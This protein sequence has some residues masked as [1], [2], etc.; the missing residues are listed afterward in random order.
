[1]SNFLSLIFPQY[2]W[3]HSVHKRKRLPP[4]KRSLVCYLKGREVRLSN[5]SSY[6]R[7]LH[8]YAAQQLPGLLKEREFHLGTL[9][10]V[11]ASQWLNHRQVV[12]GTKCNTVSARSHGYCLGVSSTS[13]WMARNVTLTISPP[14]YTRQKG[15]RKNSNMAGWGSLGVEVHKLAEEFWEL[16]C[17]KT[18]WE[19]LGIEVHKLPEEFWA[20]KFTSYLGNSER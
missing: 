14:G 7:L 10:K 8:A 13:R 3:D 2:G 20:L 18:A 16:K 1:M 11:F 17:T 4:V 15:E 9:N 19:I 5:E 6:H 12:C